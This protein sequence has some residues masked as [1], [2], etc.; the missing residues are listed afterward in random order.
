M[1]LSTSRVV[2]MVRP[3]VVTLTEHDDILARMHVVADTMRQARLRYQR[4][5]D[6]RDLM[7]AKRA[8]AE[9]AA[10]EGARQRARAAREGRTWR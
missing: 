7:A 3:P 9:Y 4:T 1:T 5:F 8:E 6:P 10:L 2:P